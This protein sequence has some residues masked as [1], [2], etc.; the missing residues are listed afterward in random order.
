MSIP[1]EVQPSG[2]TNIWTDNK[3]CG[4]GKA[5]NSFSVKTIEYPEFIWWRHS[6]NENGQ[7][8]EKHQTEEGCVN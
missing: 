1:G 7:K 2:S 6:L 8:R 3:P 5:D 4:Q